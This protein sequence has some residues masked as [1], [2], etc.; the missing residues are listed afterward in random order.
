VTGWALPDL[1]RRGLDPH[2]VAVYVGCQIGLSTEQRCLALHRDFG[3]LLSRENIADVL[4]MT[5]EEGI[6]FFHD[7]RLFRQKLRTMLDLSFGYLILGQASNTLSGG[8]AQRI[9][10]AMELTKLKHSQGNLYIL[11]EPITGLHL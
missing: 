10:L 3:D 9:K 1:P 2:Q 4:E 11:D 6:D 7:V 8:E 5:F